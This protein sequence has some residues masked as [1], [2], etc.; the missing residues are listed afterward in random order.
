M[1][2]GFASNTPGL[3]AVS[4]ADLAQRAQVAGIIGK[5]D[6]WTPEVHSAAFALPPYIARRLVSAL[7]D[8]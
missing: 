5:T 8:L 1:T 3:D 7:S 2:L 4:T 6:Y